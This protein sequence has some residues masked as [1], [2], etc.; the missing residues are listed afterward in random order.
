MSVYLTPA[1]SPWSNGAAERR[2]GAVDLTIRKMI[3]DDSSL[4]L[5]DALNHA[6]WARNMEV[7]RHGHSPFQ[8]VFGKSPAIPGVSEGNLCTDS[9]NK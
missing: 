7:G 1:Y 4:T 5:P 2:H 3:E 9:T 8:I 6:L